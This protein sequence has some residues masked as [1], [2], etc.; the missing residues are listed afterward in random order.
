MLTAEDIYLFAHSA[1]REAAYQ[2]QLPS[3]RA[4]MHRLALA[5]MEQVHA[6]DLGRVNLE[7]AQHARLA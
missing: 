6:D 5:I 3:S 1:Y 4:A 2:L 7:L